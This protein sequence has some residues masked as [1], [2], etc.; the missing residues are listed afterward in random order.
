MRWL[1]GSAVHVTGYVDC[2]VTESVFVKDLTQRRPLA[3]SHSQSLW[4]IVSIMEW[5]GSPNLHNIIM[6]SV[7]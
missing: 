6:P 1:G 4:L 5:N 7:L 3:L 2:I